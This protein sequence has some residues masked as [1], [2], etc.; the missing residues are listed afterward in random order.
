M[1]VVLLLLIV[2]T[3][4]IFK[5]YLLL[6]Y[7]FLLPFLLLLVPFIIKRDLNPY[8][9]YLFNLQWHSLDFQFNW[10]LS[11]YVYS[12]FTA[13]SLVVII[14]KGRFTNFQNTLIFS[15]ILWFLFAVFIWAGFN[16]LNSGTNILLLV[17]VAF[18]TMH[19]FNILKPGLWST[20]FFLVFITT[21]VLS[22]IYFW[23]WDKD[24]PDTE[25]ANIKHQLPSNPY[26]DEVKGKKILVFSGKLDYY[27]GA[28]HSGK[29]FNP[30]LTKVDFSV[31]NYESIALFYETIS[32]SWPE[33]IID[34]NHQLEN[35]FSRIPELNAKYIPDPNKNLWRL[36]GS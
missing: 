25:M 23:K 5:R 28:S 19:L 13:L 16:G 9:E 3:N 22:N 6:L 18:F 12:I 2:Y 1:P 31:V 10:N 7:G 4:T 8:L 11:L 14:L 34:E 35:Y 36:T 27:Y 17:P 32:S 15:M 24:L 21:S 33:V 29:M 26:F 30:N 20:L